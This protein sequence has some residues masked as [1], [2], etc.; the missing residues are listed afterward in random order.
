MLPSLG[1][2]NYRNLKS[3]DIEKLARVNLIAGKNNTGKTS[4]L[5]AVSLYASGGDVR[6]LN[7]LLKGRDD[8]LWPAKGDD[9]SD[10]LRSNIKSYS[11]IFYQRKFAKSQVE[12]GPL[13]KETRKD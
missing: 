2:R 5:E 6:W 1:I 13:S 7:D 10:L 3:L 12:I 11:A 9:P 4:L 8:Y